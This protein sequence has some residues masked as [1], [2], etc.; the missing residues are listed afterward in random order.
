[1]SDQNGAGV[2]DLFAAAA[3]MRDELSAQFEQPALAIRARL[4]AQR[5]EIQRALDSV[6]EQLRMV[7]AV[8]RPFN[9]DGPPKRSGAVKGR[10]RGSTWADHVDMDAKRA[11]VQA[12]IDAMGGGAFTAADLYRWLKD[13]QPGEAPVGRKVSIEVARE[14]HDAGVLVIERTAQGGHPVYR[15]I[16]D[17][18]GSGVDG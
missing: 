3:K 10:S 5:D 18:V 7:N 1:M 9:T 6:N 4:E 14:L 13:H 11:R 17:A 16:Q 12:A 8:L 15:R 2:D